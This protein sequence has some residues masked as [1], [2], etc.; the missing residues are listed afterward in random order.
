MNNLSAA[1]AAYLAARKRHRRIVTAARIL[2]LVLFLFIWEAAAQYGLID[3]FIF[4]SPSRIVR[5]FRDM[6]ADGSLFL[7]AGVTLLETII[8]FLLVVILGTACAVLLWLFRK[9][10]EILEPYLVILNSLP[11]SALAPLLIVWLG[12]NVRTIIVAGMS[13]A[14]FGTILNLY[15]SF[16]E[17]DPD[18][19]KLIA[20][21][22]GSRMD[23]LWKVVL[24]SNIPML[25]SI[26]KVNI[27]LSLVGVVIGEFIGARQ[28]LGYLIIYGS[29]VFKLDWVIMSIVL[30]CIIAMA[31]YSLISTI[32]KHSRKWL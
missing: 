9:L 29:Q 6:C 13:V 7:H 3:S 5:T 21:L 31:L 26:S 1:Q 2:L 30:L 24:P 12:A 25:I 27:G 18:K 32:E 19:L 17:A 20:T 15:A 23:T 11:K 4:S 14:I 10:S 28:G 16:R 22:G 8:S